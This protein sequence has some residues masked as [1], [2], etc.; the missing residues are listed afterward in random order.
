M[1]RDSD[2]KIIIS[3][4]NICTDLQIVTL[5]CETVH[6]SGNGI[7]DPH[8]INKFSLL[9]AR[10]LLALMQFPKLERYGSVSII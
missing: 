10:L 9:D 3:R 5:S 6:Y 1:Q 2:D 8:F 7:D 4:I